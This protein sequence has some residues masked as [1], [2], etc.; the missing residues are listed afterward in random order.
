[1]VMLPRGASVIS[2]YRLWVITREGF[3]SDR[4]LYSFLSKEEQS[5]DASPYM[6]MFRQ[7]WK[8]HTLARIS[9]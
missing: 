6:E 1:M 9:V 3:S 8:H 2:T 4:Q 5:M 7:G